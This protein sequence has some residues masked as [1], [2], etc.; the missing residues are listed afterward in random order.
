[1]PEISPA[2]QPQPQPQQAPFGASPA[3]GPTPNKGY[4]AAG[5]QRL[6][7]VIKQLTEML[8]LIGATSEIGKSVMKAIQDL[9]K[10]VPAG[11]NNQAAERNNLERMMMQNTQQGQQMQQMRQ[12]QA[13]PGAGAPPSMPK[14]A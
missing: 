1:M 7:M 11:A 2:A 3:T 14:A 8:P 12:Q 13:Q 10:H 4:E 5:M 6:G 9:A